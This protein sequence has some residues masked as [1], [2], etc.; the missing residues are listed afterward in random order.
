M[1]TSKES[2]SAILKGSLG[3][4]PFT[5]GEIVL[6]LLPGTNAFYSRAMTVV[7]NSLI[8]GT[9]T[10]TPPAAQIWF[11]GPSLAY[12]PGPL[13]HTTL[14]LPASVDALENT[15]TYQNA[16]NWV[17]ENVIMPDVAPV[18]ASRCAAVTTS[19]GVYLFWNQCKQV[20]AT[21]LRASRH[22]DF[23]GVPAWS[24][25][26]QLT[27]SS[28][29][30]IRPYVE[31]AG[32]ITVNNAADVAATLWAGTIIIVAC[33]I[34]G[35]GGATMLIMAFNTD[36]IDEEHNT[37]S[38]DWEYTLSNTDL[39]KQIPSATSAGVR[40]SL[41]W[42]WTL[43]A[44]A[45]LPQSNLMVYLTPLPSNRQGAYFIAPM[46]PLTGKLPTGSPT[47]YPRQLDSPMRLIRDPADRMRGYCSSLTNR[48]IITVDTF[49]TFNTI[50]PSTPYMVNGQKAPIKYTT[51]QLAAA[52][53]VDGTTPSVVFYTPTTKLASQAMSHPGQRDYAMYE[54]LFYGAQPRLQVRRYGTITVIPDYATVTESDGTP[55]TQSNG[56]KRQAESGKGFNKQILTG[57][58]DGPIP[59]PAE[60]LTVGWQDTQPNLGNLT[61][62]EN[63]ALKRGHSV[64]T[65]VTKGVKIEGEIGLGTATEMGSTASAGLTWDLAFNWTGGGVIGTSSTVTQ[66]DIWTKASIVDLDD[67]SPTLINQLLPYGLVRANTVK[68]T[69][70]IIRIFDQNGQTISDPTLSNVNETAPGQFLVGADVTPDLA[71]SYVPFGVIP[72]DL[73]SYTPLAWNRT[74]RRLGYDA[75]K[76]YFND[77]IDAKGYL[78]GG[79]MPYLTA[80]WGSAGNGLPLY[81]EVTGAYTESSWQMDQDLYAGIYARFGFLVGPQGSIKLQGRFE[82]E[83]QTIGST[84]TDEEWLLSLDAG[85]SSWGPPA[86]PSTPGAI[87]NYSFR[88]Y[89]LPAP[90]DNPSVWA[91]ELGSYHG[92]WLYDTVSSTI[93]ITSGSGTPT[94]KT[95]PLASKAIS[96]QVG[97]ILIDGTPTAFT[98]TAG[99]MHLFVRGTG[100][101][102]YGGLL[103][104]FGKAAPTPTAPTKWVR[105]AIPVHTNDENDTGPW[106]SSI[107]E[108]ANPT[109]PVLIAGTPVYVPGNTSVYVRDAK[110]HLLE[111]AYMQETKTWSYTDVFLATGSGGR[112]ISGDPAVSFI[113]STGAADI[114]V[115][116]TDNH[117]YQ[118]KKLGN[119]GVGPLTHLIGPS[120]SA[121]APIPCSCPQ[122]VPCTLA[123]YS[124]STP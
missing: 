110:G 15:S 9:K 45:D 100:T 88:I 91:Q 42:F 77:A 3:P 52:A 118:F 67:S 16:A 109:H 32:K 28:G 17:T 106:L 14:N 26:L 75:T 40:V 120:P 33:A 43:G 78:F 124:A 64:R 116:G 117:L 79:Q 29:A 35:S 119:G 48:S 83:K 63:T 98:D 90:G 1:T 49:S 65:Q 92:Q 27:T 8:I 97:G 38:A 24:T 20:T 37:W 18:A 55:D 121:Q 80:S 7:G 93:T 87:E 61:Y 105:D 22:P 71:L 70:T 96:L 4:L 39:R 50:D 89:F 115:C 122:G 25:S 86:L 73:S 101:A 44:T 107:S 58:I 69:T 23:S 82:Y 54:F 114:F 99:T 59:I 68:L 123:P 31:S 108:A 72:G 57:I 104:H 76:L 95:A 85:G 47:Y 5:S 36:H 30:P 51:L 2:S 19:H 6:T 41:D 56:R 62:G 10:K 34:F 74:M 113:P 11:L 81:S 103:W 60:N 112:L 13:L 84:N 102:A 66:G 53:A 46:D 111:F 21:S 12:G 94:T